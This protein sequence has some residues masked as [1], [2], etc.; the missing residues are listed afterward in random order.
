MNICS[1]CQRNYIGGY[2]NFFSAAQMDGAERRIAYMEPWVA[3]V[4]SSV[5]EEPDYEMNPNL[6]ECMWKSR[7]S[8][9]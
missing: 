5:E 1:V 7:W 4:A 3:T 9:E 8:T 6:V 2:T